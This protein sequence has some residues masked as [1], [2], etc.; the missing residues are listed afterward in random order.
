MNYRV[1]V[2]KFDVAYPYGDK[3]DEFAKLSIFGAEVDDLM[4]AEVG[5]KDYGDKDNEDLGKRFGAVKETYPLVMLF[6]R[7]EKTKKLSEYKFPESQEFKVENL[8]NW[9]KHYSGIYMPLPG[10]LEQFDR[11]ADKLTI[12]TSPGNTTL[13]FMFI[14]VIVYR[15]SM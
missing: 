10:C 8:K 5:I 4:V 9:I 14:F 12:A 15:S 6:V 13:F 1:S 7:D 2:V 11:L 3:H